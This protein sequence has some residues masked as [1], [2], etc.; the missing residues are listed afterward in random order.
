MRNKLLHPNGISTRDIEGA[1][2]KCVE[3][4]SSRRTNPLQPRYKL[5]EVTP[6]DVAPPRNFMRNTLDISDIVKKRHS[7]FEKGGRSSPE[8]IE[9]SQPGKHFRKVEQTE[10]LKVNDINK[11]G[12]FRSGRLDR[13][14]DPL[15]PSYVW[16]DTGNGVNS[17]YGDIG[18][19]PQ[20]QAPDKNK[21]DYILHTKDIEGAKAN[22]YNERRHLLNV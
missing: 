6:V 9:G 10:R 13:P 16:R 2:P 19:R 18:N 12:V 3:F 15:N 14:S 22:S 7:L 5:P 21:Q 20:I 1:W 4:N 17:S 11:D 8:P